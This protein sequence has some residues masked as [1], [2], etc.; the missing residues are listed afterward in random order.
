M[1]EIKFNIDFLEEK[2]YPSSTPRLTRW[3]DRTPFATAATSS[4]SKKITRFVCSMMALASLAKK[5]S[6]C[7]NQQNEIASDGK[8]ILLLIIFPLCNG[9]NQLSFTLSLG[10][11]ID[12][13]SPSG[14]AIRNSAEVFRDA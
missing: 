5:Y 9:I 4:S 2:T 1:K 10:L 11:H 14:A 7:S 3:I 12:I 13:D 6:T 8:N